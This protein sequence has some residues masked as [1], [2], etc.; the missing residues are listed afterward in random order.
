MFRP[1]CVADTSD[2]HTEG[3]G[4][5]I[6]IVGTGGRP[7][8]S[9]GGTADEGYFKTWTSSVKGFL[10]VDVSADAMD[11]AFKNVVGT[12]TDSYR[13]VRSAPGPGPSPDF[14]VSTSPTSV[15]FVA[16]QSASTTVQVQPANGFAGAIDLAVASSPAGVDGGC[17]PATLSGGGTATCVLSGSTPG[18]YTVTITGTGASLV[19]SVAVSASV[20][21][22]PP[23][24]D[25]TPPSITITS[26]SNESTVDSSP[27]TIRGVASDNVA[28]EKVEWSPDGTDW[29]AASGTGSW[30]AVVPLSAGPHT[31]YVRATDTAGNMRVAEVTLIVQVSPG[32]PAQPGDSTPSIFGIRVAPIVLGIAAGIVGLAASITVAARARR[33]TRTRRKTGGRRKQ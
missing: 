24:P 23:G 10:K 25:T 20:S 11:V 5:V 28:I 29:T 33:K 27:V 21:A 13:I 16:G 15:T 32:V 1:E 18:S 8:Y 17:S 6:N 4:A 22:P 26:P 2:L 3:A 14:S 7:T 31:I 12:Y 9:T 30:S 19:R